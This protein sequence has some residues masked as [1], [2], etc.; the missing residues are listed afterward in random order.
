MTRWAKLRPVLKNQLQEQYRPSSFRTNTSCSHSTKR[1]RHNT[2]P[3]PTSTVSALFRD[4]DDSRP[5]GVVRQD[6]TSV[7]PDRFNLGSRSV[8]NPDGSVRE[9]NLPLAMV[10]RPSDAGAWQPAVETCFEVKFGLKAP[11][12]K[13]SEKYTTHTYIY[14]RSIHRLAY[15]F[16][17]F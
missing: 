10:L 1:K 8:M 11:R 13:A 7:R 16:R 4:T 17:L 9:R 2:H 5:V 15:S 3:F 14:I 12:R 6:R